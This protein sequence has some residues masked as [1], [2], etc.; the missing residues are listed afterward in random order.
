MLKD[1]ETFLENLW[2]DLEYFSLIKDH[3]IIMEEKKTQ[4]NF[5]DSKKTNTNK[6]EEN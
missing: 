5:N 1:S 3:D 6:T 4:E 2:K